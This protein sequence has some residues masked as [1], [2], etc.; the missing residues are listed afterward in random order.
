M[1]KRLFVCIALSL[2]LT[3]TSSLCSGQDPRGAAL[4]SA[5]NLAEQFEKQSKHREAAVEYAKARG[6]ASQ[7]FGKDN[8]SVAALSQAEGMLHRKMGDFAKAETLIL[9]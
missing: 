5:I 2:F 6:F 9:Q 3:L 8:I 7:M 1:S 4:S